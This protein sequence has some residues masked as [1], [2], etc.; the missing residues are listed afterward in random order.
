[1]TVSAGARAPSVAAQDDGP[2]MTVSRLGQTGQG[3]ALVNEVS[4]AIGFVDRATVAALVQ[5]RTGGDLRL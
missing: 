2:P 3:R 4:V 5:Q 1:V